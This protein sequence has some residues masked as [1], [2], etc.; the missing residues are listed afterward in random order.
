MI[1]RMPVRGSCPATMRRTRNVS[2]SRQNRRNVIYVRFSFGWPCDGRT[3]VWRSHSKV[4]CIAAMRAAAIQILF[5]FSAIF[6]VVFLCQIWNCTVFPFVVEPLCEPS[7][8]W[9]CEWVCVCLQI[10]RDSVRNQVI[11]IRHRFGLTVEHTIQ[12]WIDWAN[13]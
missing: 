6:R 13:D 8:Q 10:Y 4:H 12:Q 5:L 11:F 7:S 9:E 2:T 1:N 3:A